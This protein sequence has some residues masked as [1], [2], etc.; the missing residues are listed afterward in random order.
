MP[1]LRNTVPFV[2]CLLSSA[3]KWP[4]SPVPRF[5]L[6]ILADCSDEAASGGGFAAGGLS[7]ATIGRLRAVLSRHI[8]Q[9]DESD[10]ELALVLRQVVTEARNRRIRAEQL[11]VSLKHLWDALPEARQAIDREAQALEKQRLITLCIRAY[12]RE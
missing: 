9:P 3:N 7:A 12:Y 6:I 11:I 8:D 5:S 4:R 2:G 1:R 10:P